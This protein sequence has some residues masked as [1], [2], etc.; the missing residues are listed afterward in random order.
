[1]RVAIKFAYDG[2]IFHGYARQLKLKT[3]EGDLIKFLVKN[4]I[5]E[6]T[7]ESIFR[8]ASRTDKGV[9]ALGNVLSF[10]T[11]KDI[12]HIFEDLNVYD[13]IVFY[14][15]KQVDDDFYPRYANQ[16][17]YRYYFKDDEYD[18]EKIIQVL[19]LFIG[20]HDFSNFARIEEHKNPI[21]TID[22]I[23]VEKLN[24]FI[25]IDFYA[26]TYLWQ[27]IRRIISAV[28]KVQHN[29]IT[30][31]MISLALNHPDEKVDFGLARPEPLI[32]KSPAIADIRSL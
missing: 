13:D 31:E 2:T 5:I 6:D 15:I 4:G 16:R 25:I 20:T 24:E 22:N 21:R 18:F 9:S 14:G 32:L 8:S 23:T 1:M 27:Q 28:Q 3:V 17:I 30:H 10:K 26:Q 12:T 7:K 19:N 29:K 11:D